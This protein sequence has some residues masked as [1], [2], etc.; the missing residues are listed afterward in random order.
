VGI[1][2]VL[3]R[4]SCEAVAGSREGPGGWGILQ[5]DQGSSLTRW[6]YTAFIRRAVT[7]R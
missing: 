7:L 6:T 4:L 1:R 3:A 2:H 5:K